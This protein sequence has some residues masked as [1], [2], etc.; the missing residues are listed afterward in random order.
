MGFQKT[1][2]GEAIGSLEPEDLIK[3]LEHLSSEI[4]SIGIGNQ[5]ASSVIVKRWEF[6]GDSFDIEF[7]EQALYFLQ[8]TD[9][10]RCEIVALLFHQIA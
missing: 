6:D 10:P 1:L 4:V 9:D 2:R 7:S 3:H 5:L 8:T